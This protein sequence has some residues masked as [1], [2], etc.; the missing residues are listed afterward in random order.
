M[1]VGS[2][3]DAQRCRVVVRSGSGCVGG[4][5][6]VDGAGRVRGGDAAAVPG[7]MWISFRSAT[8]RR[9]FYG[10]FALKSASVARRMRLHRDAAGVPVS[11]GGR[12][13]ARV[14]GD[15][16]QST[17]PVD[18]QLLRHL[19][20]RRR[21]AAVRRRD[22]VRVPAIRDR[23]TDYPRS[24]CAQV[25]RAA[26]R[27]RSLRSAEAESEASAVFARPTAI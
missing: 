10:D 19:A 8:R 15:P 26:R 12:Q 25:E 27:G 6:G 21:P 18:H 13:R 4:G 1:A 5:G 3:D 7:S 14:S 23:P 17:P 11:V 22:A 2:R 16:P 20:R 24:E 9:Q